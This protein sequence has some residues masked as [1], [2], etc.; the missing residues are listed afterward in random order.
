MDGGIDGCIRRRGFNHRACRS[1]THGLRTPRHECEG[2][3]G[4]FDCDL[5]LGFLGD[6]EGGEVGQE[7]LLDVGA[8]GAFVVGEDRGAR[9]SE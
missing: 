2:A 3:L 5:A 7:G 1:T 6:A 4:V 9:A 8:A